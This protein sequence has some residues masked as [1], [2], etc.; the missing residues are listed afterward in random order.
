VFWDFVGV[1]ADRTPPS[2]DPREA[3]RVGNGSGGIKPDLQAFWQAFPNLGCFRPS[4]SKDS[5]GGF[6][7]FQW[8]TRA[9]NPKSLLPNFFAAP[10]SFR[11]P[12]RRHNAAFYRLAPPGVEPAQQGI[13]RVYVAWWRSAGSSWSISTVQEKEASTSSD[14]WKTIVH[15]TCLAVPPIGDSPPE[16]PLQ[17]SATRES[18]KRGP[19]EPGSEDDNSHTRMRI[20]FE[21]ATRP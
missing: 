1:V 6:L 2:S 7:G 14:Y 17:A 10:A 9:K 11:T 15:Q 18:G 12:F 20:R 21:P 16:E 4:I 13:E 5:F 3:P 8:V 19:L